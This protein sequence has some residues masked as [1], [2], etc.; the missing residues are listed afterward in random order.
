MTLS[1]LDRGRRPVEPAGEAR[2]RDTN[3]GIQRRRSNNS[4]M[5]LMPPV[6][7]LSDA[8]S[9]TPAGAWIQT[10]LSLSQP[11]DPNEEEADRVADRVMRM[12]FSDTG[13]QRKCACAGKCDECRDRPTLR[14][15]AVHQNGA[16]EVP[17]IVQDALRSS[18]QPLE[19][20]TRAVFERRFGSSFRNVRVHTDNKAGESASAVNALAYT[21][22]ENIVFAH[23]Q[24]APLTTTGDRLIAHELVHVLQ[25]KGGADSS[26]ALQTE[27]VQQSSSAIAELQRSAASSGSSESSRGG[28]GGAIPT[29]T[30]G[31][32]GTCG[33]RLEL[34]WRPIQAY[35]GI[36]GILGYYHGFINMIDSRCRAHNLFVDPSLHRAG[37]TSHSHAVDRTPGW[38]TSGTTCHNIATLRPSLSC[39]DVDRLPGQTSSYETIDVAYDA[40]SGPNSN[41]FLEWVLYNSGISMSRL[42]SGLKAWDYYVRNPSARTSP[43]RVIRTGGTPPAGGGAT[44]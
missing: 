41:S 20:H 18:G 37:S 21:V 35:W 6:L 4:L 30:P 9:G 10:K 5:W 14:R 22:G 23:G 39:A 32:D 27:P 15:R 44:P 12:S 8:T 31:P 26:R 25:Q 33:C 1:R 28:T 17:A 42:P 13:V 36:P 34:C 43:P 40:T 29:P 11:G 16:I 2:A 7:R 19:T 3:S 24:Y 38:D